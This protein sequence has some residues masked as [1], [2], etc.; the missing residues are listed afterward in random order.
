MRNP[1]ACIAFVMASLVVTAR[2][3]LRAQVPEGGGSKGTRESAGAKQDGNR[4]E[5][6]RKIAGDPAE[7]F[8]NRKAAI[9]ELGRCGREAKGA[10]QELAPILAGDAGYRL[11]LIHATDERSLPQN[12]RNVV[13]VALLPERIWFRVFSNKTSIIKDIGSDDTSLRE[14]AWL[15]VYLRKHLEALKPPHTLAKGEE[16]RVI[17]IAASI[18]DLPRD[19]LLLRL[20]A[21]KA[22]GSI[23]PE[24][25]PSLLEAWVYG[26]EALLPE[27]FGGV[28]GPDRGPI[29]DLEKEGSGKLSDSFHNPTNCHFAIQQE[30]AASLR[31]IYGNNLLENDELPGLGQQAQPAVPMLTRASRS[32][33]VQVRRRAAAALKLIE[34]AARG[35]IPAPR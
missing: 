22:M 24:A 26:Y 17:H 4:V 23:G 33:D 35:A 30:A 29:F 12:E 9:Q 28:G 20:Y 34:P 8:A 32:K 14:K 11:R 5:S 10:I 3:D 19:D 7:S 2:C 1:I 15:V 18:L 13:L 27:D 31:Q 25:I 16:S 6:L 21:A